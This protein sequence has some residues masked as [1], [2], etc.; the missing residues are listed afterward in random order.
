MERTPRGWGQKIDSLLFDLN[1]KDRIQLDIAIKSV[2]HNGNLGTEVRGMQEYR[3]HKLPEDNVLIS[4]ITT[5]LNGV[6]YVE[7][8]IHSVINQTYGNLEYIII[9]GG[10][11]DGTVDVIRKYESELAYWHSKPDLGLAHGFNLGLAQAHGDWILFLNA[12]DFFLAPEVV[13][14]MVPHL[15]A[16]QEADVVFG[17]T[18]FMTCRKDPEP[19][20]LRQIYGQPWRWQE[21]RWLCTIPHPSSFTHRRYFEKVGGFNQSFRLAMDYE[22]YLRAGKYLQARQVPIAVSGMREGGESAKNIL[23]AARENRIAQQ[24]SKTHPAWIAW[25]NFFWYIGRYYL[26]RVSHKILD[27]LGA[28]MVWSGRNSKELIMEKEAMG[29]CGENPSLKITTR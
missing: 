7:Q 5:V 22:L 12:D 16:H 8:T 18:I 20:S 24:M 14:R 3:S 25:I 29:V 17:K 27:P 4:V 26:G 28:Q 23:R 10:S 11:T 1:L 6:Q 13:E 2:I 9:D 19:A 15:L 21:Y